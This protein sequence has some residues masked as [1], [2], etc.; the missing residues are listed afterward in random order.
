VM[1]NI[2][3]KFIFNNKRIIPAFNRDR[4]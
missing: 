3:Q 2:N 1:N 4:W